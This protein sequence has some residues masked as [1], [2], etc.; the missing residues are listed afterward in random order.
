M[1]HAANA[2]VAGLLLAAGASH[3]FGADKQSTLIRG[4][5][6]ITRAASIMLDAGFVMPVVV[7][8]PRAAEHRP[9]LLGLP[10]QVVQN[11][12]AETGMASS[13]LTALDAA[14]ECEAVC[15]TVCDQPAVTA[16]H[17]RMLVLAWRKT[18]SSIV[19]SSYAGTVGVPA[20]FDSIHFPELR[21]LSGDRG[22]GPLL[23]RHAGSV[24]TIPLPGG[25]LDIDTPSDLER[26]N[27]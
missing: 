10:L 27:R 3:R 7:L 22:A 8:G 18:S 1:K 26:L 19:A 20:V 24:Y 6:L 9:L 16:R 17:L 21:Q 4:I 2:R 5:P 12:S 15:V 23:A 25:E 14:G 11:P 13:L